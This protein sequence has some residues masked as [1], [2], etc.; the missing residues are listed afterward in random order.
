MLKGGGNEQ[1][2][3]KNGHLGVVPDSSKDI[4]YQTVLPIILSHLEQPK[5]DQALAECLDIQLGQMRNWLKKAVEEGKVRKTKKPVKYV[6][7][8]KAEQLSFLN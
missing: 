4:I 3:L 1:G 2:K 6:V 8:Q 5:D 7:N